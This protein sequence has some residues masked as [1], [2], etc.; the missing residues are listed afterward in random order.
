M[1]ESSSWKDVG[2]NLT[3]G[4]GAIL[5][6]CLMAVGGMLAKESR[7]RMVGSVDMVM[8]YC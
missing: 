3:I 5:M 4:S 8:V 6:Y 7:C 2:S 1:Q